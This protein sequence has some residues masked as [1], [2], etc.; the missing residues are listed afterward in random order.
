[1]VFTSEH[2]KWLKKEKIDHPKSINLKIY[3][4][5]PTWDEETVKR[6]PKH[7]RNHYC[8][9]SEID[10]ERRAIGISR[11]EY[12][13]KYKFPNPEIW[14]GPS[15]RSGDFSE[16][17]ILDYL[18]F[19]LGYQVSRLRNLRKNSPNESIKGT[20]VI[21]FKADIKNPS[22]EDEL[23]VFEVK[24]L[25][26]KNKGNSLQDAIN[27]S[28]KDD[29]RKSTSLAAM[30]SRHKDLNNE[31]FCLLIERFQNKNDRPYIEKSGAAAIITSIAYQNFNPDNI[32]TSRHYNK[33][34]L[35]LILIHANKLMDFVHESYRRAADE[36]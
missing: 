1:M 26:T 23:I 15:I 20:D 35:H 22:K 27:D 32:N 28:K 25:L 5:S 4:F 13:I 21:G 10:D 24:A 16:I 11:K 9:D 17:F 3:H 18:N 30:R 12:L 33:E 34:K 7:L 31:N 2:L 29:F 19:C 36:A 8:L 6:W 14:L